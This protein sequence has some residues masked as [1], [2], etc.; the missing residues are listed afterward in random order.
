M[1]NVILDKMCMKME[2][3]IIHEVM[4]IMFLCFAAVR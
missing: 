1:L 2:S 3:E 4:M